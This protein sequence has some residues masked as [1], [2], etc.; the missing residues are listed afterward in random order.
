MKR[1]IFLPLLVATLAACPRDKREQSGT[2]ADSIPVAAALDT[3]PADLSGVQTSLPPAAPDTFKRRTPQRGARTTAG[4]VGAPRIPPAPEPLMA[5]VR[6]EQAFSRFC[7]QEFGQKSDPTLAGGVAMVVTVGS[8]GVTSAQVENDSWSSRAG[9]E[10]NR[11]L[12]EKA[13]SAWKL[14]PGI[15]ESGKYVVQ[16]SFRGS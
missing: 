16:L 3:T 8:N 11:C 10:V 12:N 14:A 9:N 15:V 4:A 5:A 13:A 2:T 6:R 7:Y 1:V